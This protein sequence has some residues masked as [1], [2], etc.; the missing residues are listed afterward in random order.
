MSPFHDNFPF[1]SGNIPSAPTYGIIIFHLIHYLTACRSYLYTDILYFAKFLT[2][3]HTEQ[4]KLC[5]LKIAITSKVL[6]SPSL[7]CLYIHVW[8]PPPHWGKI[9]SIRHNFLLL[10]Y[11]TGHDM[12]NSV[13]VSR[14][15]SSHLSC[16]CTWSKLLIYF[17]F[18]VW[19]LSVFICCSLFLSPFSLICLCPLTLEFWIS[20]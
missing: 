16:L 8:C 18:S 10:P 15:S 17:W 9:Y 14:K 20:I 13:G 12:R 6:R 11:N 1:I 19:F 5:C 3:K 2:K 7:T 4:G